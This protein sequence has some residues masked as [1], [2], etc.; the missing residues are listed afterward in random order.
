[1]FPQSTEV[2]PTM[3]MLIYQRKDTMPS[4]VSTLV[5]N[6]FVHAVSTYEK[7]GTPIQ[8]GQEASPTPTAQTQGKIK[9]KE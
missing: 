1:M 5:Q 6:V 4:H 9:I 7:D 2:Q 8:I 3:P